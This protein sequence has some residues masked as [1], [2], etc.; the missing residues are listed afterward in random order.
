MNDTHLL[1]P[2]E[3]WW[4]LRRVLAVIGIGMLLLTIVSYVSYQARFLL[5]GP[6]IV[7]IEEPPPRSETPDITITG[8]ARNIARIAINGRQIFTDPA[9]NFEELIILSPGANIITISAVDR[10]GRTKAIDRTTVYSADS[11]IQ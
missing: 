5:V 9:G 1:L 11:L 3:S 2:Q 6:Q 7:L 8:S 4:T 10:Y